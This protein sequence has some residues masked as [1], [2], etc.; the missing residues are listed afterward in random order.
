MT[1]KAF[2]QRQALLIAERQRDQRIERLRELEA[3]YERSRPNAAPATL[4]RFQYWNR[5]QDRVA[6]IQV[7]LDLE[8]TEGSPH[9]DRVVPNAWTTAAR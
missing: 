1:P 2:R 7:E 5:I 3:T 9:L 6:P 4:D 8:I